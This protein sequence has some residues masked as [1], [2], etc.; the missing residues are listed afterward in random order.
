VGE[1]NPIPFGMMPP[2]LNRYVR[3]DDVVEVF[4]ERNQ[5]PGLLLNIRVW[6]PLQD[7][8]GMFGG[9]DGLEWRVHEWDLQ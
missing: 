1:K 2:D 8:K 3:A 9:D 4:P 7:K 6:H 5:L